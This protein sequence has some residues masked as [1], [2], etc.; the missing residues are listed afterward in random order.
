MKKIFSYLFCPNWKRI[1]VAKS[2]ETVF[3]T[4]NGVKLTGTEREKLHVC[5]LEYSNI[6][7]KYRIRRLVGL[8]T[9]DSDAYLKCLEKQ[10]ELENNKHVI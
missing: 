8:D 7:N 5:A 9:S 1:Y 10:I 3:T 2:M 4:M 6:R